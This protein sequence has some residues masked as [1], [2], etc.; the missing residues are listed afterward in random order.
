[1]GTKHQQSKPELESHLTEQLSFLRSSAKSYDEGN[2]SE[3]K[4]IAATLRILLHDTGRSKSLLGQLERLQTPFLDTSVPFVPNR[5]T[6]HRGLVHVLGTPQ[7]PKFIPFFDKGEAPHRNVDFLKW[8][9]TAIFVDLNKQEI[10]RKDVVLSMADQDGGAH[11]DPVLDEPYSDLS[12]KNSLG[13]SVGKLGEQPM[14]GVEHAAIRQIAHEVFKTLDSQYKLEEPKYPFPA[15]SIGNIAVKTSEDIAGSED[16][17]QNS[18][19][20]VSQ[21]SKKQPKIG[22]NKPCYCGSGKKFKYCHGKRS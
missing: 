8:W 6:S 22:R 11:V 15:I 3:A 10:T 17:K 5:K 19:K 16:G 13:I 1:M 12:R 20:K 4:R 14:K 2:T 9:N 18:A 7:G 21:P